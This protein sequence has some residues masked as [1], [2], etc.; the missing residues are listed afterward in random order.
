MPTVH[1]IGGGW[2]LDEVTVVDGLGL[3]PW[4]GRPGVVEEKAGRVVELLLAT[5]RP[6]QLLAGKILGLGLLGFG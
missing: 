6:W 2:D 1:P 5:M 3:V 4:T